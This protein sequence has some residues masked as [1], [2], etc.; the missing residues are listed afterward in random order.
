MNLNFILLARI[1]PVEKSVFVHKFA[2]VLFF[3]QLPMCILL[4]TV[5]SA[6]LSKSLVPLNLPKGISSATILFLL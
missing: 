6:F 3:L 1:D 4:F 5:F 2:F